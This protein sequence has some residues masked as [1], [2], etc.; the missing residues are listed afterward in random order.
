MN[1]DEKEDNKKKDNKEND[2]IGRV[3]RSK[4]IKEKK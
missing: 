4:P 2:F 3:G 1:N